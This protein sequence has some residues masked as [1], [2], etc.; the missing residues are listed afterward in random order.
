[1]LFSFSYLKY[2]SHDHSSLSPEFTRERDTRLSLRAAP[3]SASKDPRKS[4]G[5]NSR[6]FLGPV[7]LGTNVGVR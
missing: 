2:I 4:S 5:A 1:M 3:R 7:N 6:R